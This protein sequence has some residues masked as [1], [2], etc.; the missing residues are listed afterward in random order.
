MR[1]PVGVPPEGRQQ[2]ADR[3]IVGNGIV[4]RL[5][6]DEGVAAVR[7]GGEHAAQIVLRL[8]PLL[9]DVVEA[10]VVRLP[11]LERD[12]GQRLARAIADLPPD[13][14]GLALTIQ[15]NV[16]TIGI[17][18]R[19]RDIERPEHRVLGRAGGTVMGDRVDQHRDSQDVGQQDEFLPPVRAGVAHGGEEPDALHPF[20]LGQFRLNHRRVQVV[21]EDRHHLAQTRRGVRAHTAIDDLG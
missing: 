3:T 10:F 16:R 7:I 21:D 2:L 6:A 18:R 13:Q 17:G 5:D 15:T 8:L 14:Q 1:R 19:R 12:P 9:L 4:S 20:R 11:D